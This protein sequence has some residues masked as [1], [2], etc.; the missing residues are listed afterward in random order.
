MRE[1]DIVILAIFVLL[2]IVPVLLQNNNYPVNAQDFQNDVA[3]AERLVDGGDVRD[4]GNHYFGR[5][6]M[7]YAVGVIS[8]LT[9]VDCAN[10]QLVFDWL[11]I[12][13]A[14][15]VVYIIVLKLF[16]RISGILAV[17]ASFFCVHSIFISFSSGDIWNIIAICIVLIPAL[18]F[19][20][21]WLSERKKAH[22]IIALVLLAVFSSVH[23]LGLALPYVIGLFSIGYGIYCLIKKRYKEAALIGFLFMG[24]VAVSL[25][26]SHLFIRDTWAWNR[27]VISKIQ[28]MFMGLDTN[29]ISLSN[30]FYIYI[31]LPVIGLLA[32]ALIEWRKVKEGLESK[33]QIWFLVLLAC[34]IVPFL[35][36]SLTGIGIYPIRHAMDGS[37][38]LAI[39]A[40][41]LVGLVVKGIKEHI[42]WVKVLLVFLLAVGIIPPT[43]VWFG[44]VK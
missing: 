26:L 14:C 10:I 38:L 15:L 31:T 35:A 8:L 27:I 4:A 12:L 29:K 11:M 19:L 40:G 7:A 23:P 9:K 13:V 36:A 18:Y 43:L 42:S 39:G 30:L 33:A 3:R 28:V 21:R 16:G 17:L 1:K 37:T 25:L 22:L 24:I 32:I 20:S 2:L 5:T 34:F 44:I 6:I 41:C